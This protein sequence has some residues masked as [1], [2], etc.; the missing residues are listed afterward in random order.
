MRIW[1]QS[2]T[3]L[4]LQRNYSATLV[5]QAARVSAPDTVIDVHGVRPGTYPP[6]VSAGQ[7]N[8]YLWA[9]NLVNVQIIEN[10]RRAEAQGYDAVA[11][12][13]FLDPGLDEARSVVD[14]PVV[15]MCE[16][17]L[18]LGMAFGRRYGLLCL[19]RPGIAP[20][21]ELVRKH[22]FGERLAKVV[23]VHPAVTGLELEAAYA[24]FDP[25]MERVLAA[26]QEAIEAGA[27]LL[28]PA[29]GILNTLFVV[30]GITELHGVPI[31]DAYAALIAHA[32]LAV[33]LR[34]RAGVA[35]SHTGGWA[36]PDKEMFTSVQRATELDLA[37]A[38]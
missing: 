19:H 18:A 17:A 33:T 4:S 5:E 15:S 20:R 24:D 6:G 8:R 36:K 13:C 14:I 2:I 37:D 29:E 34:T 25:L 30:H 16:S 23:S 21:E 11:M 7:V 9:H 1:H 3:D 28:V 31:L 22:G 32:E 12:S 38:P 26:A 10:V 27:D 35:V